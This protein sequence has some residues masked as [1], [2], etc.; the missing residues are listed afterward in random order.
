MKT[1]ALVGMLLVCVMLFG[2]ITP[3]FAPPSSTTYRVTIATK[4][5]AKGAKGRYFDVIDLTLYN[6]GTFTTDE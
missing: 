3:A 2:P 6:D 5:K 4:A 1:R